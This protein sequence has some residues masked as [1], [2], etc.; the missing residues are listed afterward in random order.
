[1]KVVYLDLDGVLNDHKPNPNGYNSLKRECVEEFNRILEEVPDLRIV[2]SSAWRYMHPEAM[3]LKGFEYLLLT[4]G[5]DCKDRGLGFTKKD[6]EI[7]TRGGQIVDY[8]KQLPTM[9]NYVI[10]DDMAFDFA[11]M[12]LKNFIQTNSDMGLT[13]YDAERAIHRLQNNILTN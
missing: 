4:H 8:I 6:E 12:G 10:L 5:I 7:P 9:T 1:M 2:I 13:W 11:E 3:T